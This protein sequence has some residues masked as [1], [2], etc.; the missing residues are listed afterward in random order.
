MWADNETSEDLLGFDFVVDSLFVALTEPR[1]LPLTIGLLG[2]WGSGKSSVLKI[3]RAELEALREGDEPDR[4]VCVEFSPW[5][6]EDY[7]DVKVALMSAV[8]DRL[9]QEDKDTAEQ[10][11]VSWL[12]R[13]LRTFRGRGRAFGRLAL[14][15]TPA[16]LSGASGFVDPSL[17]PPE[18]LRATTTI[19]GG[20][21]SAGAEALQEPPTAPETANGADPTAEICTF[22]REFAQLVG[23]LKH[24]RAVVVLIDDL[25]RCLP[26]SVVDTFE[27]VRLFLNSPKTAFVV[28]A[29]QLV[30]ESA[31]DS[32]YPELRRP[33]GTGIGA[34]YLEKMLQLK[35]AI[36]ALSAPEAETYMNLLLAELRLRREL[37]EKVLQTVHQRRVDNPLTVAFNLGIAEDCIGANALPRELVH[38]LVWAADIAPA[39]TAGL[40]GN[41]R[42]LKRFL[43][44]VMLRSRSAKRRSIELEPAVIA[45]LLVLEEQHFGDFKKLFD[46]QMASPGAV[47]QLRLAETHVREAMRGKGADAHGTADA[48]TD[49]DTAPTDAPAGRPRRRSGGADKTQADVRLP[50]EVDEWVGREHVQAWLK[51]EPPLA[52]LDLRPYFTY[53]RHK[54]SLGVVVARLAPR[55]QKLL[56]DLQ[57]GVPATLRTAAADVGKLAAEERAQLIDALLDAVVRN[58]AGQAF[59]AAAELVER[60]PDVVQVVCEGLA[61]VPVNAV[62][63]QRVLSV[64]RHLPLDHPSVVALLDRWQNSGIPAL[65]KAVGVVRGQVA[66]SGR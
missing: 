8:L 7:D 43:N 37:F 61:R 58:P 51:L 23:N 20:V 21:A 31:I 42:Q 4:Y 39:L 22:K 46:W 41:P 50:P 57:S 3:V 12:R 62:P 9:E 36:P 17:M 65:E 26:E 2:D 14:T 59:T 35:V 56:G 1:L 11:R 40:R 6:Y 24:V 47:E 60:I 44:N 28:A 34:D 16:V 64:A 25:D 10:E 53:S 38:D 54:L 5:Q 27:A 63:P 45:K 32:K 30:V 55:L 13:R 49:T 66:R 29:N 19:L 52:G 18:T 48:R 15:A 33:D